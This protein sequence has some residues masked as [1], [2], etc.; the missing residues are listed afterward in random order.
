MEW[1]NQ[2]APVDRPTREHMGDNRWRSVGW[3]LL[4]GVLV[5]VA[6]GIAGTFLSP[7]G[8]VAT[9][10][11]AGGVLVAGSFVVLWWNSERG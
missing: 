9:L 3:L 2:N 4:A 5:G 8:T 1:T 10:L 7:G 6:S 11:I